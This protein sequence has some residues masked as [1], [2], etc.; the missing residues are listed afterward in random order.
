MTNL[1][2]LPFFVDSGI[3][4]ILSF[5]GWGA[6]LLYVFQKKIVINKRV[7]YIGAVIAF[8]AALSLLQTW[9]TGYDYFGTRVFYS[10]LISLFIL[11]AS[12]IIPNRT[13]N[14]SNLDRVYMAYVL[15]ATI[16]IIVIYF[17]YFAGKALFETAIYEYGS[18]NS[19]SQIAIT[20]VVLSVFAIGNKQEKHKWIHLFCLAVNVVMLFL[21]RSRASIIGLVVLL[22]MTMFNKRLNKRVRF[23][24]I[25][26]TAIAVIVIFTNPAAYETIVDKILFGGREIEDMDSLTS[27]RFSEWESFPALFADYALWGRGRYKIEAFPLSALMQYGMLG[28]LILIALACY[29]AIYA[30]LNR[31]KNKHY[32]I[33]L[34]V[35]LIYLLN[36]IF[37]EISPFGPGVKC[38]FVWFLLGA[39]MKDELYGNDEFTET[40]PHPGC[41]NFTRGTA[42][43]HAGNH[44]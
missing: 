33:L 30:F 23:L 15:S 6:M 42:E 28:G 36:G 20:A 26:A 8:F 18:K 39:L 2:Q 17:M 40:T 34:I 12:H 35:M 7:L 31:K 27:G 38:Y 43:N 14:H 16:L 21:M 13:L 29:P 41:Q 3:T 44:A 19:T 25:A 22:L 11:F 4:Q 1:S 24:L 32:S 37:E 9:I 10:L 5:A